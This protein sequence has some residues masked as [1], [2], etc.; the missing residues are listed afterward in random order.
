MNGQLIAL[1]LAAVLTYYAG[2]EAVRGVK[3]VGREVKKGGAAVVH[4]LKKI[5]RPRHHVDEEP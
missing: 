2:I 5:P 4:A 1:A 3:W